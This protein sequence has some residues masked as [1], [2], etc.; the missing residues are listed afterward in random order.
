MF[1]CSLLGISQQ[2]VDTTLTPQIATPY[3]QSQEGP[4]VYIDEIHNN[5]HTK[6]G[7]FKPFS[8]LLERDGYNVR[9]LTSYNM[10]EKTDVIVISNAIHSNNIG[11][12]QQPI[13]DAFSSD[14][15][16]ILKTWVEEGGRLLIIADHMP[17]S[18]ATNSL[19][20]AF[21]FD[22]C[23]G[24]AQLSKPRNEPDQFS[25]KNKRLLTSKI[26][27]G[28]YGKPLKSVTT[29]T[30][31]SF[32]IPKKAIGILKF[33]KGDICLQ[34]EI[35]WQFDENTPSMDLEDKYQGAIM[36][37]GKGKL[38][39]FG[40]AAQ[41]TAQTVT[42]DYGTFHVGFHAESAPNNVNF[43]RNLMLWLSDQK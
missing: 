29:F 8:T 15:I 5:F 38:A 19:A 39:V 11:N 40:E 2:V 24:F 4:T 25:E 30:G 16:Q 27:N 6:D 36:D 23:D 20:N 26:T 32:Q 22:F 28:T 17:F 10:L 13:Y 3:Y 14:D 1:C 42:N 33:M 35:A 18:G 43:L 41:F 21:G 12:W 37:F 9:S 31:S 7:R 34:P